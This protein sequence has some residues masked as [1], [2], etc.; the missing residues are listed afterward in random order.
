MK[1][2]TTPNDQLIIFLWGQLDLATRWYVSQYLSQSA[3]ISLRE[4]LRNVLLRSDERKYLQELESFIFRKKEAVIV[5]PGDSERA[6][7]VAKDAQD[8][9]YYV[10]EHVLWGMKPIPGKNEKVVLCLGVNSQVVF[11]LTKE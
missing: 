10:L 11:V 6:F 1:T 2:E 5:D 7:C 4:E 3:R 8:D 9:A